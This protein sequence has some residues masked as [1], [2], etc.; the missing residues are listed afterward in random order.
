VSDPGSPR[1][2]HSSRD[3]L[4]PYGLPTNEIPAPGIPGYGVPRYEPGQ[5]RRLIGR[6]VFGLLTR[7]LDA[8]RK[9]FF[10]FLGVRIEFRRRD[11]LLISHV[12]DVELGVS[13]AEKDQGFSPHITTFHASQRTPGIRVSTASAERNG[14]HQQRSFS[15]S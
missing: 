13:L 8:V 5:V 15:V 14:I 6:K 1:G 11:D 12:P 7:K 10:V 2:R 9:E 4:P 3:A